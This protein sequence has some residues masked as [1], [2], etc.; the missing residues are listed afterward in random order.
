MKKIIITTCIFFTAVASYAQWNPATTSTTAD[1]YRDGNVGIALNSAPQT[2]FDIGNSQGTGMQFRYDNSLNYRIRLSPYWNTGTDTRLD[3]NIERAPGGGFTTVMSV[4]YNNNVGLGTT[5]PTSR[6]TLMNSATGVNSGIQIIDGASNPRGAIYYNGIQDFVIDALSGP[7][8]ADVSTFRIRTGGNDR[9]SI[10]RD[11]NVGIGTTSPSS[12]LTLNKSGSGAQ[13]SEILIQSNSTNVARLGWNTPGYVDISSLYNNNHIALLPTGTGNVGVGTTTP[14]FKLDVN[15]V[16]AAG[17]S[18]VNWTVDDASNGWIRTNFGSNVYWSTTTKKWEVNAIGNN[19]F[20]SIIHTNCDGLAFIAAPSLGNAPRSLDNSTF[21]SYEKMRISATGN[22]GVGTSSP[23]FKL[24][25]KGQNPNSEGMTLGAATTGNFAL[26]SA[27]G[28]AYGLFAGVSGTGRAWLQA[29]R[30]DSNVA[31]DLLLQSAGGNV[32][33]GTKNPDQKLTVKG[34][35]HTEE[36]RVDMTVAGPDYVFEK[37]YNLLPLSQV[38][39]YINQNKHLPEVPSAKEMEE[40][41]LNLK[42]MNLILLKKVEEL[43]L[44][45]IEMKKNQEEQQRENQEQQREIVELKSKIK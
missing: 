36:V 1:L 15:G 42:E 3:F 23:A 24:H 14:R 20:T 38:E 21:M 33:I 43:T 12:L 34:V 7:G 32:G 27:D 37:N 22:I 5:S 6:L 31:Y 26:T 17:Y 8:G 16:I 10:S 28:G 39:S 13:P 4:G 30:Y 35:I 44:H 9:F 18:F 19:D 41:G 45:L 11:G 29:G 2:K 25:I 40:N